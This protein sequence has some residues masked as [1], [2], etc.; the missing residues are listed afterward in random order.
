MIHTRALWC[1]I[2]AVCLLPVLAHA[3]EPV[4]VAS[5]RVIAGAPPLFQSQ[6]DPEVPGRFVNFTASGCALS[7][8]AASVRGLTWSG[9][10]P[11]GRMQGRGTVIGYDYEQQPIFVFEGYIEHGLRTNGTMHEVERKNGRLI[12]LRTAIIG[13]AL[14]PHTEV[15]FLDMPRPFLLAMDDWSRQTDGKNLLASMGATWAPSRAQEEKSARDRQ[16]VFNLLGK[17]AIAAAGGTNSAERKQLALN[18]LAGNSPSAS[19]RLGASSAGPSSDMVEVTGSMAH[20]FK[21]VPAGND[22]SVDTST[23]AAGEPRSRIEK[24]VVLVNTCPNYIVA[25]YCDISGGRDVLSGQIKEPAYGCENLYGGDQIQRSGK[26]PSEF[27]LGTHPSTRFSFFDRK[28][29]TTP[30]SV[31]ACDAKTEQ[32][33]VL[34]KGGK[35]LAGNRACTKRLSSGPFTPGPLDAKIIPVQ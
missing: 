27:K 34:R 21:V 18:A 25:H 16:E 23:W 1:L 31:F 17:A 28:L 11:G 4:Q 29:I 33:Q 8:S 12:G 22:P 13:S 10:C 6:P 30:R 7:F 19:S 14:Q 26:I 9:P 5:K 24:A 2:G 20:C 32:V 3:Q 35:T 15:P